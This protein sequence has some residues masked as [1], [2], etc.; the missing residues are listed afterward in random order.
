MKDELK[1]EIKYVLVQ[2]FCT[3]VGWLLICG[4]GILVFGTLANYY[5]WAETVMIICWIY[6]TIFT[7]VGIFYAL[8]NTLKDWKK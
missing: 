1:E 8:V 6:P 4:L 5:D 3:K 7:L 2:L